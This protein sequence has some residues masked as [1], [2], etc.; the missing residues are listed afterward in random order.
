MD[1]FIQALGEV[2][3]P[4]SVVLVVAGTVFGMVCG[5][6]PGIST[7]LAII[8]CLPFTYTMTPAAAVVL[9]IA[10]Y[11]GGACGGSIS[12]ILI[13]SPGTPEAVATTFDGYPMAQKGEAGIAL[14]LAVTASSFGTIFSAVVM[15]IAAPLLATVALSFQSAEYF[16]L[17]LIGLSCITS[18]AAKDQMKAALSVILGL[19]ISTIGIDSING[20]ER[21][22]FG[23]PFLLNGIN[24][25]SVMIGAFAVAEV[26]KNIEEYRHRDN[27]LH[28]GGRVSIKLMKFAEMVKMWSTFVTAS[29]IGVIIGIIPAAGG[30]ISSLIAY[31]EA[32][33]THKNDP[34]KFGE[35]NPRG[36]VAP[37]ASNNAGVG[38]ALVPTMVLGIPGSPVTAVIMAAFIIIGMRPGPLLLREQPVL[39]NTVFLALVFSA[40]LL[41]VG[42]RFVTRQFGH[43]LKL[44]YPLLGPLIMA[45]GLVGAYSLQ[46]SFY[47]VIVMFVF[48]LLGYL[49][50]KFR[51]SSPALILGLILGELVENSLRKQIIIGDGSAAG[52]FN[53]P[54]SLVILV[55]AVV[56]LVWPLIG[57]V[58]KKKA[59]PAA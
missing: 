27:T 49:F 40:L 47:D 46:N 52:F 55:T 19:M 34:I 33:R 3:N 24:Y 11:V 53:R 59:K 54:I 5:A 8:L 45:L 48:G 9:L 41:F 20:T 29:I 14:G 1:V 36:V 10:V 6:L 56:I 4:L 26:L 17:S 16:G 28:E 31:G 51:Y 38:G 43:I 35:G 42:G 13:K 50:D 58:L 23:Q 25:I 57:A 32:S 30:S 44:P 37:E 21:F 22:A 7:S 39:L 2:F 18:I 15:L 12:A